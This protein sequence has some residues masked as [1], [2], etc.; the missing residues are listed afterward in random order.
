[1]S[2]RAVLDELWSLIDELD[3]INRA[4]LIGA[5]VLTVAIV[6]ALLAGCAS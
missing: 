2:T 3:G 5:G 6:G 4:C 1:M